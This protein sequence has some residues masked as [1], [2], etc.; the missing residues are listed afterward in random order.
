MG[1]SN[2]DDNSKKFQEELN[3]MRKHFD[4]VERK[5]DE[6]EKSQDKMAENIIEIKSMMSQLMGGANPP[7]NPSST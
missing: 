5:Q 4:N 1:S 7:F 6:F 3:K 2:N